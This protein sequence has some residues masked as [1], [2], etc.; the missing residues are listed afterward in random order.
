MK[1]SK[2]KVR[3]KLILA[4]TNPVKKKAT[5]SAF[6]AMFPEVEFEIET[7][8][9][10]SGVADQPKT[11]AETLA[12]AR[13]RVQNARKVKPLAD[14]WVGIEGGVDEL[15]DELAAFAWI[16]V[17]SAEMTGRSRTGTFFLP[18]KITELIHQGKEL[19]EADDIVFNQQNSKQKN[20]AIGLLTRNVVTRFIL[21]RHAI[22]LA[23]VP[24]RNAALY[25]YLN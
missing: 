14:F 16:V 24:F 2:M 23:L 17:E 22:I 21:Y 7:C 13:N 3:K 9:V 12:G 15:E 19:G 4:S 5:L 8:K 11:S 25:C 10:P 1:N 6:R 18:R 20:G